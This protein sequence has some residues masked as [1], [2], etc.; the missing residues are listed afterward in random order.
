M[1]LFRNYRILFYY[2]C[3]GKS[4]ISLLHSFLLK[5][6]FNTG[7]KKEKKG[8][9][10]SD[11]YTCCTG[12][13]SSAASF[14]LHHIRETLGSGFCCLVVWV[15]GFFVGGSLFFYFFFASEQIRSFL[16]FLVVKSQRN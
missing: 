8:I 4:L 11:P 7:K 3:V 9:I 12:N 16:Y 10:F 5:E 6:L 2:F 1:G 13:P 14:R 15:W